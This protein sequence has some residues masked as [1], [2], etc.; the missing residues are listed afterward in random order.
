MK[1]NQSKKPG[2]TNSRYIDSQFFALRYKGDPAKWLLIKATKWHH[3]HHRSSYHSYQENIKKCWLSVWFIGGNWIERTKSMMRV[4]KKLLI[5]KLL[6]EGGIT[7][8][9]FSVVLSATVKVI[10]GF[11]LEAET[12]ISYISWCH[13]WS[14]TVA[15]LRPGDKTF[16][17]TRQRAQSTA[18]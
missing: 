9:T 14:L 8:A 4:G 16:S 2:S 3:R 10:L 5:I 1:E 11:K 17:I 13:L 12:K 7:A 18:D 15:P 6:F